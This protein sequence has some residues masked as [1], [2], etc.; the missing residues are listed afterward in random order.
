MLDLQFGALN[1]FSKEAWRPSAMTNMTTLTGDDETKIP[2]KHECVREAALLHGRGFYGGVPVGF[3]SRRG[4]DLTDRC[5]L[6][7]PVRPLIAMVRPM[8]FAARLT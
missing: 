3:A 2:Q 8:S 7:S 1:R 4:G 6:G 5:W